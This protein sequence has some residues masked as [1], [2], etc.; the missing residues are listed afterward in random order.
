MVLLAIVARF[1][2]QTKNKCKVKISG[3]VNIQKL[4]W[5]G[6]AVSCDGVD[7]QVQDT[8]DD[9]LASGGQNNSKDFQGHLIPNQLVVNLDILNT[10]QVHIANPAKTD[11][12]SKTIEN[13]N[14]Y[15]NG[16]P[17]ALSD[18][19]NTIQMGM[20]DITFDLGK[21]IHNEVV[22]EVLKYAD[23]GGLVPMNTGTPFLCDINNVVDTTASGTGNDGAHGFKDNIYGSVSVQSIILYFHYDFEKYF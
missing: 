16:L 5:V 18:S 10:N 20:G 2:E 9:T 13:S 14:P 22:V 17:L 21:T 15:S 12:N 7:L 4:K 6:Y 3:G 8:I 19:L 23:D 11:A 1:N